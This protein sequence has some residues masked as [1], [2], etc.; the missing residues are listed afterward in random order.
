MNQSNTVPGSFILYTTDERTLNQDY[1]KVQA[2]VGGTLSDPTLV[3]TDLLRDGSVVTL[4]GTPPT[5]VGT[6][7]YY[8]LLGSDFAIGPTPNT[9]GQYQ[10]TITVVMNGDTFTSVTFFNVPQ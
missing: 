1:S 9:V 3:V 7:V 6:S 10:I 2:A 4:H 8:Q 5:V